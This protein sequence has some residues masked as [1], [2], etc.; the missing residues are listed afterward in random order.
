M[1]RLRLSP[2][3][4]VITVF[5]ADLGVFTRGEGYSSKNKVMIARKKNAALH[6]SALHCGLARTTPEKEAA[7]GLVFCQQETAWKWS[8]ITPPVS[9]L[10]GSYQRMTSFRGWNSGQLQDL[11]KTE[12]VPSRGRT[13]T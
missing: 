13:V 10:T 9:F 5:C 1:K 3:V 8:R 7:I 2:R 12:R 11:L 6:P 4:T